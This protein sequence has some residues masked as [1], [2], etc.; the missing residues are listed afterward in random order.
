LT[1]IAGLVMA[2]AVGIIDR[3]LHVSD[4]TA[5]AVLVGAGSVGYVA[6]CW[7]LDISRTRRRLKLGFAFFRTKL[8]NI[9]IG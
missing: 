2:L 3:N 7:L 8:A 1:M 6:M 9:N 5:C 4:L